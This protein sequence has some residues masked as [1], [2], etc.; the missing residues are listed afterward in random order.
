[1]SII[2]GWLRDNHGVA[3][4]IF[5]ALNLLIV[6][7]VGLV[8]MGVFDSKEPL[9]TKEEVTVIAT[10]VQNISDSLPTLASKETVSMI[11]ESILTF[12]SKEYTEQIVLLLAR[13]MDSPKLVRQGELGEIDFDCEKEVLRHVHSDG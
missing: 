3:S 6:G 7:S 4:L 2:M 9:A 5:T 12:A 10:E 1:M 13:C 8:Q 11:E